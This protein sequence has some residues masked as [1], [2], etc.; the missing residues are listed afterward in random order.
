VAAGAFD[1]RHRRGGVRGG[2]FDVSAEG[3]VGLLRVSGEVTLIFRK[4]SQRYAALN[5][6][7]AQ[8][9]HFIVRMHK[10]IGIFYCA[11]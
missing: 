1:A 10:N 11:F 2:A 3:V 8:K 7:K 4:K 5:L 6:P 9:C